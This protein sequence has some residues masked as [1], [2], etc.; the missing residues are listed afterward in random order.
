MREALRG[1]AA[2]ARRTRSGPVE[3]VL[4]DL[5]GYAVLSAQIGPL[6]QR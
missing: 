5:F 4:G 3:G 6:R 1:A 2:V